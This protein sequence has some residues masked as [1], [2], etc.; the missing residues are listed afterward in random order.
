M[1]AGARVNAAL[2]VQA[3]SPSAQTAARA[4]ARHWLDWAAPLAAAT[5]HL[6]L[7]LYAR[8]ERGVNMLADADRA[9]W[10]YFWQTLPAA[11]LRADLGQ[12]IANL[13]MQPPLYNLWGALHLRLFA[14][15]AAPLE[16][17]HWSHMLL[18]A[19]VCATFYPIAR[20]LG[21]GRRW[22]APA[23]LLTALLPSLVL[24]EAYPLYEMLTLALVMGSVWA[25]ARFEAAR[26][27]VWLLA[28]VAALT[29]LM[30][31]RSAF[32]L[33]LMLPALALTALAVHERRGRFLL[34]ALL[35]TLPAAGWYARNQVQFGFFGASS[36]AGM[37][38]WRIAPQPDA[39]DPADAAALVEVGR[40]EPVAAYE[41]PFRLPAAYA[42]FGF[43]QES[44]V[45]VL[46]AE[47]LNNINIVAV[48]KAYGRSALGMIRL[49]PGAY[50]ENVR[51]AYTR[52]HRP[53][54]SYDHL[55]ANRARMPAF[56]LKAEQALH[57]RPWLAGM[58]SVTFLLLPLALLLYALWALLRRGR[59]QPLRAFVQERPTAAYAAL[60]LLYATVVSS[61]LEFGENER[62]RFAVEPLLWLFAAG[63]VAS[64][65]RA[66]R[67]PFDQ[68][69]A[70]NP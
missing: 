8:F 27:P 53:T 14:G 36:W 41:A 35:L 50:L 16:A 22:A 13:H 43:T 3:A 40:I 32:H 28:A 49:R 23:A 20:A 2:P 15:D 11:T 58:G 51:A 38:L 52:F 4:A 21:L 69:Q 12:A 9:S 24:Y 31:T 65:A 62:F 10:D 66:L 55:D 64:A 33:L 57:L 5:L 45:A 47:D 44:P 46:N 48:A 30:L 60:L 26:R 68:G 19:L 18:G 42:R 37:N 1:E 6:A 61:T 39:D 29:L 7:A 59:G 70:E 17:M 67:R 25:V 34:L 56:W 63:M 54:T